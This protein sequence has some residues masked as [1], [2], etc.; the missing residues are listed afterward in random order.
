MIQKSTRSYRFPYETIFNLFNAVLKQL[1]NQNG[2]LFCFWQITALF[3]VNGPNVWK[4]NEMPLARSYAGLFYPPCGSFAIF[5]LPHK[6]EH[7]F[8]ILF[9]SRLSFCIKNNFI[10]QL[11]M[12]RITRKGKSLSFLAI[13]TFQTRNK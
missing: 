5:L 7:S 9:H 6:Y 11:L 12:N 8:H 13:P 1:H 10:N 3:V 2:K 4:M